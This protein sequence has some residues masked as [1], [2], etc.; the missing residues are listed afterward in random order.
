MIGSE[1]WFF[2]LWHL[3]LLKKN[4]IKIFHQR[5]IFFDHMLYSLALRNFNHLLPF[6]VLHLIWIWIIS[7]QTNLNLFKILI[8]GINQDEIDRNRDYYFITL[9]GITRLFDCW[10]KKFATTFKLKAYAQKSIS[11]IAIFFKYISI[12]FMLRFCCLNSY[13]VVRI[14]KN[15][16]KCLIESQFFWVIN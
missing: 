14:M 12:F 5:C 15:K 3:S 10:M 2:N 6:F 4:I 9:L 7:K 1:S 11:F 8:L 16:N 13:W